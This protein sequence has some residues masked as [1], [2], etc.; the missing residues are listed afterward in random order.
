MLEVELHWD[1]ANSDMNIDVFDGFGT[2]IATGPGL[3]SLL[4]PR[5]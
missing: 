2:Q 4:S 1:N 3:P 5:V